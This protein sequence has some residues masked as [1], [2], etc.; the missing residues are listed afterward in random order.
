MLKIHLRELTHTRL[1]NGNEQKQMREEQLS[2]NF[3]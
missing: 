1:F 2:N 3:A